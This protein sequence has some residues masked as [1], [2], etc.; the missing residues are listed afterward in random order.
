MSN[1]IKVKFPDGIE[2]GLKFNNFGIA[3][4][5]KEVDFARYGSTGNYAMVW[6]GLLGNCYA[7]REEADFTFEQVTDL[8]D[9][10]SKELLDEIS[11]VL[12]ATDK[13]KADAETIRLTI[14]NVLEDTPA[15][16]KSELMTI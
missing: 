15:E 11:L 7:K 8:V 2:R 6:G 5:W 12:G 9:A 3:E 10:M 4:F 1:Y 16:K 13:F 14:K